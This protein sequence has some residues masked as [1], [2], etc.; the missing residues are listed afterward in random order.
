MHA[1]LKRAAWERKSVEIGGGVFSPAECSEAA[2]K[3]AAYDATLAALRELRLAFALVSEAQVNFDDA[4]GLDRSRTCDVL[5]EQHRR[6]H[7]AIEAADTI[8]R[9]SAL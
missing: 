1:N 9:E 4:R 7:S 5:A 6:L 3:L 8:I 2:R